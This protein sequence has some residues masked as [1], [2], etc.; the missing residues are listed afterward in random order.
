VVTI[1][2]VLDLP[3][4]ADEGGMG[5]EAPSGGVAGIWR[6]GG[7]SYSNASRICENLNSRCGFVSYE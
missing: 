3:F 2:N 6:C 7:R 4:G 1:L 5:E